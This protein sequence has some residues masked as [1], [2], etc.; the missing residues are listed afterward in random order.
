[1]SSINEYQKKLKQIELQADELTFNIELKSRLV[2]TEH[3]LDVIREIDIAVEVRIQNLNLNS[4]DIDIRIE[5]LNEARKRLIKE[6][7]DYEATCMAKVEATKSILVA[8][9]NEA[10]KWSLRM[11]QSDALRT[12]N[13][14]QFKLELNQQADNHLENLKHIQLQ[15]KAFQLGGKMIG[16]SE[17]NEASDAVV[18]YLHINDLVSP[19]LIRTHFKEKFPSSRR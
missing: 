18:G 17:N 3:C 8:H 11:R 13:N 12:Y 2:I 15:L 6:V 19:T 14:Q 5:E 16:F 4:T 7:K 10:K 1:M 9:I